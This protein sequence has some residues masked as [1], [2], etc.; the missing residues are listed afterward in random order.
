MGAPSELASGPAEACSRP[1]CPGL[2]RGCRPGSLQG[3]TAIP[4][5]VVGSHY[6]VGRK[7][8]V[9]CPGPTGISGTIAMLTQWLGGQCQELPLFLMSD[10]HR[11]RTPEL[12]DQRPLTS[13]TVLPWAGP[14]QHPLGFGE[15]P[16]THPHT[17]LWKES[18]QLVMVWKV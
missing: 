10:H 18:R 16:L 2:P 13:L 8:P 4:A 7:D 9:P 12:P 11:G 17:C 14:T 15:Q 3:A 5:Q 6:P 1:L